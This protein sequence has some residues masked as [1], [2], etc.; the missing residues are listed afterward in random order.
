MDARWRPRADFQQA[1]FSTDPMPGAILETFDLNDATIRKRHFAEDLGV[2][3]RRG[4]EKKEQEQKSHESEEGREK[5]FES[6]FHERFYSGGQHDVQKF[7]MSNDFYRKGLALR[8]LGR[9]GFA[10]NVR[11]R[12]G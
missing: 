7:L 11:I 2:A 6:A 8:Y 9:A 12:W 5:D 3:V 4:K 10:D 1:R